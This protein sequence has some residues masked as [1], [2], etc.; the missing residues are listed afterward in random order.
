MTGPALTE[1]CRR[2]RPELACLGDA[3]VPLIG[4]LGVVERAGAGRTVDVLT[5]PAF[6]LEVLT[7]IDPGTDPA[8]VGGPAAWAYGS[9]L[10]SVRLLGRQGRQRSTS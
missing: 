4:L 8:L 2:V 5:D 3:G 9:Q 10:V 7:S 1:L 6:A